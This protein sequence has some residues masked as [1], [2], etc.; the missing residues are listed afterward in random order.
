MK[1]MLIRISY[2]TMDH[3]EVRNHIFKYWFLVSISSA[4]L[5]TFSD[6]PTKAVDDL[7]EVLPN[8]TKTGVDI[9]F[10]IVYF[11]L[12]NWDDVQ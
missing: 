5:Q 3:Y 9:T 12:D 10:D 6:N 1:E 7:L 4:S 11:L 8:K 2:P